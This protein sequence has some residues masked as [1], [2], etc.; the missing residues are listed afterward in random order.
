ME[1]EITLNKQ[2]NY[3]TFQ[4]EN[5]DILS[6]ILYDQYFSQFKNDPKLIEKVS[7]RGS[8]IELFITPE[9]NQHCEYCYIERFGDK[10]FPKEMRNHDHILK[11]MDIFLNYLI[12]KNIYLNTLD[13]FS[14]E[15]WGTSFGNQIFEK[16]LTAINNGLQIQ[17]IMFPTN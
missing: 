3:K 7:K 13:L 2:L 9:C 15:I 8:S 14:G 17:N 5:N 1:Q 10:L 16:I 6:Y 12:E 11:N 4:E